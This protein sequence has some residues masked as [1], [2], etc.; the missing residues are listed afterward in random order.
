M[1]DD[2]RLLDRLCQG[3]TLAL[4]DFYKGYRKLLFVTAV[5]ILQKPEEAEDL[6]QSFYIDFWEKQLYRKITIGSDNSLKNYLMCCI[7]N[8]CLNKLKADQFQKKAYESLKVT[9]A[10]I[11]PDNAVERRELQ[12]QLSDAI[13]RLSPQQAAIFSKSYIQHKKRKEIA[14]ELHISEESVKTQIS[15]ALFRLRSLLK[16]AESL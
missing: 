3:D 11:M 14:E 15:R 12:Q 2:I 10:Y 8:R 16:K 9:N 7:K 5:V 1:Q 6:V 13:G 4:N